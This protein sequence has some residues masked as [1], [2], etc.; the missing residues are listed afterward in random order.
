MLN[1][2]LPYINLFASAGGGGSDS[3]G[4]GALI[5]VFGW[6]PA[7]A[8]GS[9]FRKKFIKS[10]ESK[11]PLQIAGWV[12]ASV[13]ALIW[14]IIGVVMMDGIG[15]WLVIA[16]ILAWPGMGAG[17]YGWFGKI[18][19]NKAA[20]QALQQA[21]QTDAA[22]NEEHLKSG[23]QNIFTMFQRDW[24][25]FATE[26]MKSYLTPRY[27]QHVNLMM[28]ALSQMGRRNITTVDTFM[29]TQIV[30]VNDAEGTAGDYFVTGFD[31]A[32]KDDL[33]DIPSNQI[34]FTSNKNIE[35]FWWFMRDGNSWRLN[36]IQPATAASWTANP[37]M[38]QFAAAHGAFYSLDWGYLL[39][40]QRG[41]LFAG[42]KF[43]VSDINNHVIGQLARTEHIQP[44]DL[45]YQLY[46][47]SEQPAAKTN[48]KK[49][50]LIGQV[51]VP[52]N[53]GNIIVRR[54]KGLF[55]FKISGLKEVSTEWGDFNK[56]YQVF[57]TSP[58]QATSFELLNPKFMEQLEATPFEIN[59][60]VVDNT[61]YFYAPLKT[62]DATHYE[63]ILKIL[64][65][66]YR[67][68]RM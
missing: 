49:I 67:E 31:V 48:N 27:W 8:I 65:D 39:L 44:D 51:T 29:E 62:I 18:K 53:Y 11:M 56:K 21:A 4:E 68:M 1:V 12:I 32:A 52:K 57:A 46:T 47:Y 23:A 16:G 55:Q 40:P 13:L 43:G 60:E 6:L 15:F 30:T 7:Q 10:P 58:E 45:I 2:V 37:P 26:P 22:W 3:G 24:S 61:I 20:Q 63:T 17:L 42:G 66:S 38:E 35:E 64:Q 59:L 36:G 34:I 5:M 14:I 41:Q 54:R 25:T 9:S 28:C 19:A 33:V 50:Y